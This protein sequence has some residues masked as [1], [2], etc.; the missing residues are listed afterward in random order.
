MTMLVRPFAALGLC[1]AE[2]V[3]ERE[4][5]ADDVAAEQDQVGVTHEQ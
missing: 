5:E 1:V 3:A 2:A 4:I